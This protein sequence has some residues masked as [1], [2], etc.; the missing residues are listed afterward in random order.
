MKTGTTLKF[1]FRHPYNMVQLP[2]F[3]AVFF[4]FICIFFI[5]W[6]PVKI[7]YSSLESG[8]ETARKN[9]R[10][11]KSEA[12]FFAQY[13]E[14]SK[15]V[16]D[17]E[18]KLSTGK[19]TGEISSYI[20]KLARTN[21]LKLSIENTDTQKQ[22]VS[23]YDVYAQDIMVSGQYADLRKFLYGLEHM[24]VMAVLN[25]VRVDRDGT[26]QGMIKSSIQL[27]IYCRASGQA[28]KN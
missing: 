20:N 7:K 22:N 13:Q 2:L 24:N 3:T 12:A 11:A 18:Y 21:R 9:V 16:M 6:L 15:N 25:K 5:Y 23:G 28:G 27:V 4:V 19:S 10:L 14:A 8:I 17:I 1:I 26:Q